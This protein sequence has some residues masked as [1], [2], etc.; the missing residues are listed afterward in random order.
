MSVKIAAVVFT[1]GIISFA[2]RQLPAGRRHPYFCT[3]YNLMTHDK[4]TSDKTLQL[5]VWVL[6]F[7]TIA[8]LSFA[9][10]TLGF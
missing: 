1:D 8:F 3:K 5:I 2:E 4:N 6:F 10:G 7:S 9:A